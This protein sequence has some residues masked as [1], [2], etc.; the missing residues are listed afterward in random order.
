MAVLDSL[1]AGGRAVGVVSHVAELKARVAD[2]IEIRPNA[3][4]SSRL[5]ATG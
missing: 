1:R 5:R 2:R 3:D 4:G